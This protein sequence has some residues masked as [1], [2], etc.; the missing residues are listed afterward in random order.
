LRRLYL[1]NKVYMDRG[2]SYL[3]IKKW[4]DDY[5]TMNEWF[6][7]EWAPYGYVHD[8]LFRVRPGPDCQT[9]DFASFW[10][11]LESR[12]EK[13]LKSNAWIFEDV[14]NNPRFL[15]KSKVNNVELMVITFH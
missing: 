9:V 11:C 3:S 4:N 13:L 14:K 6:E 1:N 7:Q 10:E 12:D 15:D 2:A 5:K 8:N